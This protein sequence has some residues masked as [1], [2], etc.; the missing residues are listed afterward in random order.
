MLPEAQS[1]DSPSSSPGMMVWGKREAGD[2]RA[3]EEEER[4]EERGWW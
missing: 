4:A 2:L 1:M 3:M